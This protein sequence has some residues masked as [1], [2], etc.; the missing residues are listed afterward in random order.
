MQIIKITKLKNGQYKIQLDN[1]ETIITYDDVVL[2]ENLLYQKNIDIEKWKELT[3]ETTYFDVY[4][5]VKNL[6]SKR[7]RSCKEI[8]TYLEK[9]S[10][11]S[12]EKERIIKELKNSGWIDDKRFIKCYIND[13]IYLSNDGPFLIYRNLLS[14]GI[15]EAEIEKALAQIDQ[16]IFYEKAYKQVEK[17]IKSNTKYSRYMLQNKIM[18]SLKDKGFEEKMIQEALDACFIEEKSII[19][20]EYQKL[21][22]RLSQKYVG[23]EL[24]FKIKQKLYGKGFQGEE[25]EALYIERQ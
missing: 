14:Y 18:Q 9:E 2:K 21:Y 16:N 19:E 5:K 17:K 23:K 15:E 4:H 1:K 22:K 6:I 3:K 13:R 10:I 7:Y 8:E 12:K 11:S 20:K 25:I 24:M